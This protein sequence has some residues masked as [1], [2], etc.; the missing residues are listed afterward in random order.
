MLPP[1]VNEAL[2]GLLAIGFG[3]WGRRVL[4]ALDT[5]A[6]HTTALAVIGSRQ[7]GFEKRLEKVEQK[8]DHRASR[9]TGEVAL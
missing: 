2:L 4:R 9:P 5:I 1:Y 7:E 8:V 6:E 3:F